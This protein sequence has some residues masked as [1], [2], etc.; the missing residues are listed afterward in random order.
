MLCSGKARLASSEVGERRSE[1][2]RFLISA[3][4][5]AQK[6]NALIQEG[7]FPQTFQSIMEDLQP[8]AAHFTTM[9][10]ARGAYF[11]VNV[12]EPSETEPFCK[13]W[14]SSYGHR[15]MCKRRCQHSSKRHRS[16]AKT[17]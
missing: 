2:M 3:R 12:D 5:P 7:G 9:D 14:G 16:T 13:G 17:E 8:E 15:R 11:V 1:Y 6:T 4:V 10:G